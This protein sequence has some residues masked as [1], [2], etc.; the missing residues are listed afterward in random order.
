MTKSGLFRNI[1]CYDVCEF[2][3]D[4]NCAVRDRRFVYQQ[5]SGRSGL[6][7]SR[8]DLDLVFLPSAAAVGVPV[9]TSGTAAALVP[10]VGRPATAP[11]E[12]AV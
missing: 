8:P 4:M 6:A 10:V 12:H 5:S 2:S 9:A 11:A 1:L 3:E 7:C